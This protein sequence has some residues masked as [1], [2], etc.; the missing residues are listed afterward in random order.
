MYRKGSVIAVIPYLLSTPIPFHFFLK[1]LLSLTGFIC[2]YDPI[3]QH[4]MSFLVRYT[5]E[6]KTAPSPGILS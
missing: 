1:D 5:I 4:L 6:V 3:H 2:D